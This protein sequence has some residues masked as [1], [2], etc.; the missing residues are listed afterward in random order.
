M[1]EATGDPNGQVS[2]SAHGPWIGLFI[3]CVVIAAAVGLAV[4]ERGRRASDLN[5]EWALSQK[6]FEA[7][8]E[9]VDKE[10]GRARLLTELKLLGV[11]YR[12]ACVAN[13]T[14]PTDWSSLKDT[15]GSPLEPAVGR[16]GAPLEVAWSVD[17]RNTPAHA[18]E[19]L[20]AWERTPVDGQ[21][22]VLLADGATSRFVDGEAFRN[23][24]RARPTPAARKAAKPPAKG[25]GP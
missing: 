9:A 12:M 15:D 4:F 23:A 20:L 8:R 2:A 7:K 17:L 3:G 25:D 1:A 19:W 14:P 5:E 22:G 24:L 11:L 6:Q 16:D 10:F 21:H 13:D 18:N